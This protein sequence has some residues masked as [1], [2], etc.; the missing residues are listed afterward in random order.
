MRRWLRLHVGRRKA[1][2]VAV[3][4]VL[5]TSICAAGV[6]W[7]ATW[8]GRRL[9][10]DWVV[11]AVDQSS[12]GVYQVRMGHVHFDWT[13]PPGIAVDSVSLATRRALNASRPQPRPG[14]SIALYRCHISGVQFFTLVANAGFIAESFGCESGNLMV[15]MPRRARGG[16]PGNA[17]PASAK[18]AF[19]E[20]QAFLVVQQNLRLP[21]YAPRIR[22]ARVMFPRL[23]LDVRMPR[24]AIGAIGLELEQLEWTM[25]GVVI[26]PSDS[27]AASRPLFSKRID[28]AASNF[29]TH[30]DRAT[31]VRVGSLRTSLIDSTLEIRNV[32]FEPSESGAEFRRGRRY[33]HDIINLN[34][35]LISAQGIDFGAFIDGQGVRARR[36][37]VDSLRIDVTSDKRRPD[38][39]AQ[40]RHRTPQEWI[41][42]LD[43]T[44]SLDSL[45]VR[46]G[47]V[48]Y[49]EHAVGRIRPGVITFAR[50]NAAAANVSHFVGRRTSEV[51]MTLNAQAH[52]Q[53]V[54]QINVQVAIPLDAPRFDMRLRGTLGA[55]PAQA[56]NQF[57]VPTGALQI[58]SGQVAGGSFN[59]TIKHGVAR[60]A[61]TPRFNDLSVS[62]TRNGS[63]GILG[64]GGIIGG[65]ARGIAS[66]AATR[67]AMRANNPDKATT[68]P[69]IGTI[70]H[71]FK[72]SETLIAFLWVSLRDGLL[73]VVKK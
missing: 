65:A 63:T 50:I 70:N 21:S 14:L 37:D 55:M 66:F 30:P 20:R 16:G 2:D 56:F 22:I 57:A 48:V 60:G 49:R 62:I 41:A 12:D 1:I 23:V 26:D 58:E 42:D 61:I 9:L 6:V 59:M 28:L 4:F 67:L 64:N 54:G 45:F 15:Q 27:S 34:V 38:G 24:T 73:S 72:S 69:R 51:P 3:M 46:N 10:H 7:R 33:R 35:G 17:S 31:A 71:T 29:V 47:E 40:A 39:S 8:I 19:A 52:I 25:E 53:N 5:L 44:L 68:A 43:E 11:K 18:L 36:I 13:F 32:S